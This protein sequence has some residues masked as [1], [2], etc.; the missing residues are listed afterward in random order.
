MKKMYFIFILLCFFSFNFLVHAD[1]DKPHVKI[2]DNDFELICIY[3]DGAELT[4]TK[5]DIYIRNT[6]GS[7][8]STANSGISFYLT[9]SQKDK[10]DANGNTIVNK[11]NL[12]RKDVHCP[13]NL[14]L[15]KVESKYDENV[16]EGE[17]LDDVYNYY[18]STENG[19]E[20]S[21]SG[22]HAGGFLW[23]KDMSDA[24]QVKDGSTNLISEETNLLTS[25]EALI[26]DYAT[27]DTNSISGRSVSIYI[28]GNASFLESNNRTTPLFF[29]TPLTKCPATAEGNI[30]YVNNPMPRSVGNA[31]NGNY[32]YDHY[33]F[34][35]ST[36][37]E[38]CKEKNNDNVCSAYKF[39]GSRDG[40]IDNKAE[41]DVCELLGNETITILKEVVSWLQ[42]I[43]PAIIIIL[44]GVDITKM[45]LAGNLDE[46]LPKKKKLII[47]RLIVMVL[48]FFLP[49]IVGLIIKLLNESGINVGDL[50]CFF[51]K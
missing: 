50:E 8:G 16:K 22:T 27:E 2:A 4:I 26:C 1:S 25:K 46:E 23:L 45:V 48:F 32:E 9:S 40:E 7:L 21:I 49:A 36:N 28:F 15:Y 35:Q 29:D 17:K 19:I 34:Y 12:L 20:K 44:I 3:S 18:Y 10:K 30:M 42:I 38:K 14:Y 6:S 11:G 5:E 51:D 37:S 41:Q 47:I 31:Y 24:T 13:S 33:R 39:V 43:V